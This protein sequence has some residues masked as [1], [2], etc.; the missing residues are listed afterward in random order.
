MLDENEVLH[1][2]KGFIDGSLAQAKKGIAVGPTKRGKGTKW[3]VVIDGQGGSL[4]ST[5]ASASP[6]EFTLVEKNSKR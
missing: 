2:L 4:G 1:W 3:K 5:L 6:S